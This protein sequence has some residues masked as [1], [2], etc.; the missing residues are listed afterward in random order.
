[1]EAERETEI[2]WKGEFGDAYTIRNN[3][4]GVTPA[5]RF[6][7]NCL[8]SIDQPEQAAIKTVLELGA[9]VGVNLAA[10]KHLIPGIH[11]C[12]IEI[13]ESAF[14]EL[15]KTADTALHGS[16]LGM[17]PRGYNLVLTKGVLIHVHPGDL[18]KTYDLIY[19][20]SNRWI[21]IAEYY[22]PT[23]VEKDYRGHKARL[24]KRDFAGEMLEAFPDLQLAD[25]GFHYHL[26]RMPQ[27]DLNWFLM[28][29]RA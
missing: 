7:E 1:M 14:K 3:V 20:A 21:L 17:Q 19:Q 5:I 2:F 28:E 6:L 18:A 27:D 9:N 15:E 22:S 26:D 12:G 16:F 4:T 29:K 10:L 24:W 8:A 23:P 25:Y 13:N 11:T